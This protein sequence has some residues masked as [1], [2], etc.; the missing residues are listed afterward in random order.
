M[1]VSR[2]AYYAWRVRP[3]TAIEK[4][5]AD[6]IEIISSTFLKSRK[7]YGTRRLKSTLL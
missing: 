7:S 4:D 5:D 1:S 6:L 2:S 3:L